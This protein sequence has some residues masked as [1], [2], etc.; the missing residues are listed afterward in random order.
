LEHGELMSRVQYLAEEVS[1]YPDT[2]KQYAE[3]ISDYH[4]KTTRYR[5]AV[6][7]G[8]SFGLH[9][10]DA[11]IS[12]RECGPRPSA[13]VVTAEQNDEHEWGVGAKASDGEYPIVGPPI[14]RQQHCEKER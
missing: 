1:S 14:T 9:G 2:W 8:R 4:G 11:W 6:Y 12:W 3:Y 10:F 5:S 13:S 7:Y